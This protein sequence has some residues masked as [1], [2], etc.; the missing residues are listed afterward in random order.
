MRIRLILQPRILPSPLWGEGVR[1]SFVFARSL[2]LIGAA[3]AC[4]PSGAT[5]AQEQKPAKVAKEKAKPKK[6]AQPELPFPPQLPNGLAV[7][8]DSSPEFLQ[9]T[10]ELANGVTVAKTPPTI[11]F[12][13]FPGQTYAGKPWSAWGDSLFANGKY[14][15]T[16]GDHLAPQGNAFVYEFD[17]AN[18]SFRQLLDL[19]KLLALP[20]GHYT[21]G[22][23]HSRLDLGRDGWLYCS[24]HRGSPSAT[25]DANHYEGDW[26]VRCHPES[27]KSEIVAHGPVGKHCIPNGTLDGERL[28]FYGGSAPGSAAENAQVQ[29]FA[30]DVANRKRLYQ[31]DN[32]PQRYMILAS[33]SGR[34]YFT[35]GND[36]SPLMRFDPA[37]GSPP[38]EIPG[39]IGIRAATRESPA[40]D[41]ITVSQARGDVAALLYRFNTR[42]EKV[43]ELGPAPVASQTYVAAMCADAAGRFVYYVP[44][45]HGGAD[46]DGSPIVQFDT[47][48]RQRKVIAF[49]NPVYEKKYGAAPRGTYSVAVDPDGSR[50]FVTWNVSRGSRAWDCTAVTVVHVPASERVK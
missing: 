8:T 11:D 50:V 32:G 23:F 24:T 47:K 42:T 33:S 9:H 4:L 10:V 5:H 48:T 22:K 45:A 44:G 34:V 26:I 25:V 19:R 49:L 1:R 38:V 39:R 20:D 7:V 28:I 46:R 2:I 18:K 30:Y 15:A 40:G 21:P 16:I 41:V 36:L 12:V 27:G 13:Y 37:S 43:E 14:Y 31:G 17:P 35:P 3:F 29:F 6:S